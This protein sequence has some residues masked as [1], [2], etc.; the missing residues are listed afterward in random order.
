MWK[1]PCWLEYPG[2]VSDQE[3]GFCKLF[4]LSIKVVVLRLAS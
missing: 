2:A 1:K 3:S 4:F